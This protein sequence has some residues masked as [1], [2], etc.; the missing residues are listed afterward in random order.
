M[1]IKRVSRR[2]PWG[3]VRERDDLRSAAGASASGRFG[4]GDEG[5]IAPG[6]RRS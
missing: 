6:F 2:V 5:P 1:G 4:L 3:V